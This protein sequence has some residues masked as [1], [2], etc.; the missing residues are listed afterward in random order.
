VLKINLV[1]GRWTKEK[2]EVQYYTRVVRFYD[3]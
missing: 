1:G 2:V 3:Y